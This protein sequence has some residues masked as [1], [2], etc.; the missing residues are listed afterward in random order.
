M[1]RHYTELLFEYLKLFP[2]VALVGVRQCGKTTLLKE[3]PSPWK[4]Y[5]L[6]K[7]S[8]FGVISRDP[9]LF[10]RLNPGYVAFDEVQSLPE[11]FPALRVAIDAERDKLGRFIITGSSSPDLLKSVSE[12]LAGRIAVIE[13]APFSTTEAYALPQSIFYEMIARKADAPSLVEELSVRMDIAKLH[14]FW[15]KG[16]YPEPWIRN[17]SRFTG[18]W[19]DNYIRTYLNRDVMKLF[20][21]LNERKYRLF[22]QVLINVSGGIINY[23]NIAG[24]VAASPPTVREYFQIAHGTFIWRH[25]P[26]Y[27]KNALKRIVKHPKGYLRDSGLLHSML[28]LYDLDSLLTHPAMGPSWEGMV[29]ENILRGF[30]IRG[31]PCDYYYYRTGAGAEVDL[32]LEGEFGL[33]PIEIK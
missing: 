25:I 27:E 7:G 9:G 31:I 30:N 13:L 17:N 29:I 21:G 4:C 6:E 3:L 28:R 15:L 11:L 16:G 24:T 1:K 5:D 14:R 8:D 2:C 10:L 26:P 19:M 32:V 20:P 23:S 18:I 12:S 33:L 22:L